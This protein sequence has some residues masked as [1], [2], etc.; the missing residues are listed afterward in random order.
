M[1]TQDLK[2]QPPVSV[3]NIVGFSYLSLIRTLAAVL[4]LWFSVSP[5]LSGEVSQEQGS[6]PDAIVH[7]IVNAIEKNYLR[8]RSNPQWNIA[9]DHLL[10]GKFKTAAEVFQAA[11]K[12]LPFLEDSELNLLTPDEIAAVQAEALGKK[13]GLGLCNFCL[14]QQIE[15]GRARVV[16]PLMGSPAMKNGIESED[17]IVSINGENTSEMSHEQVMD[18]LHAPSPGG[19][20]LKIERGE[21]EITTILQPSADPL[22]VLLSVTK[23]V[24]GKNVGYIRVALFTP[25]VAQKAREAVGQLEQSGVDGYILDLRNNPGGFLNSARDVVGLFASGTMG[26]KVRSNGQKEPIDAHGTPLTKKPLA[27]L[28]NRGTASASEL[29]AGGLKGLHRGAVV[30]DTSY[31][32]G[33]AQ[34]FIPLAE[35]YGIQIPSVELQTPDGEGYK[36]KGIGPDVEV[37]QPPLPDDQLAGARDKQFLKAVA[38]FTTDPH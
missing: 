32:R 18:A 26:F 5:C 27:V 2:S 22:A 21:R 6:N 17:V 38:S 15:T 20:K 23:R 25:D 29:V 11:Q 3:Y 12:Q 10:T 24:A 16:T 31:G 13:I 33:Q 37:K 7:S 36:G 35:D 8:T 1:R 14:D 30:G 34:I 9:R 4:I 28:I 19:V